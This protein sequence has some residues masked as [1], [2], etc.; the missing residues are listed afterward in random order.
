[1]FELQYVRYKKYFQKYNG[2]YHLSTVLVTVIKCP[3]LKALEVV[4]LVINIFAVYNRDDGRSE[5]MVGEGK[6]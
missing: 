5:N 2:K 3:K 1:M 4:F 6:H